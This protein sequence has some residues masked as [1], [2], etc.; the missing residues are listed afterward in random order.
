MQSASSE[1]FSQDSEARPGKAF[2]GLSLGPVSVCC[3]REFGNVWQCSSELCCTDDLSFRRED[4]QHCCA[5]RGSWCDLIHPPFL[6]WCWGT[7][8]LQNRDPFSQP[9]MLVCLIFFILNLCFFLV[10]SV[11]FCQVFICFPYIF[12]TIVRRGSVKDVCTTHRKELPAIEPGLTLQQ[13]WKKLHTKW[14]QGENICF[15][16][17]RYDRICLI[18]AKGQV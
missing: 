13:W 8:S 7:Q 9:H 18:F 5:S 2:E 4:G 3:H 11:K 16:L 6:C 12:L 15:C 1:E 17:M 10:W 14:V